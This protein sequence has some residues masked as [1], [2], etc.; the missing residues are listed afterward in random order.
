MPQNNLLKNAKEMID[1]AQNGL[2]RINWERREVLKN[3]N[4]KFSDANGILY[5]YSDIIFFGFVPNKTKESVIVDCFLEL[6]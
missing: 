2:E 1:V 3:M 4:I 6:S 5:Y